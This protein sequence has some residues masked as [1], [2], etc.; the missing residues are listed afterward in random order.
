MFGEIC[1]NEIV[2]IVVKVVLMG[3]LVFLILY[4]NFIVEILICLIYMGVECYL[5]VF[6]LILVIV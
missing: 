1:D 5:I 2:E 3:Y 6:S 4:I